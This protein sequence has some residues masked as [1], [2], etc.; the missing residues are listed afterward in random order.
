MAD[1]GT[2]QTIPIDK[3]RPAP[4]QPRE[5]FDK[6]K[7]TE[8]ADSIKESGLIE[9][10]VV[11][12]AGSTY[13][14]V[15]GER[16]WRAWHE[17]G[18][19]EIPAIVKQLSDFEAMEMSFIENLQ[20]EDLSNSEK[21]RMIT[22]LYTLGFEAKRY[23]SKAD[24]SRKLGYKSGGSIGTIITAGEMR[25]AENIPDDVAPQILIVSKSLEPEDRQRVIE[26]TRVGPT[27]GGL[28]K[29]HQDLIP[30]VRA[31]KAATESGSYAVKEAVLTS[32]SFVS[33]NI[34]EKI[35]EVQDIKSQ[36]QLVKKIGIEK[37]D[38]RQVERVV[39]IAKKAPDQIK[40]AMLKSKSKITPDIAEKIMEFP[41]REQQKAIIKE[42][43]KAD[44]LE[45]AGI[46][47]FVD[48]KL[49]IA[50]G[51]RA[52]D[53]FIR[54]PHK[55]LVDLYSKIYSDVSTI[56]AEHVENMPIMYKK[57]A[58]KYMN[59]ARDHLERELIKLGELRI[60]RG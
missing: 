54:D 40:E 11:R 60:N 22:R 14:I 2:Y 27:K 20:R 57:E 43:E 38:E 50:R 46:R 1:D 24:M 48:D 31:V 35:L 3:I 5:L 53:I 16:R 32:G 6:D 9:P 26:L 18:R 23:T 55:R 15:A 25:I 47:A 10:I 17:L 30:Y 4:W 19:K 12:P 41:E 13:Q 8:L 59:N 39:E 21:E 44:E 52:P 45:E 42:I 7:I 56:S 51:K 49:D 36:E 58:V 28:P 29:D 37:L 34:A 33:P